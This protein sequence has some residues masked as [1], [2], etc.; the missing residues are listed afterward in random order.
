M[1]EGRSKNDKITN[2]YWCITHKL[3]NENFPTECVPE[4]LRNP[5]DCEK[6]Q[7]SCERNIRAFIKLTI[8]R[9]KCGDWIKRPRDVKTKP[10]SVN[11]QCKGKIWSLWWVNHMMQQ[12]RKM[13]EEFRSERQCNANNNSE[14]IKSNSRSRLEREKWKRNQQTQ[15][16]SLKQGERSWHDDREHLLGDWPLAGRFRPWRQP[17]E[18]TVSNSTEEQQS[19]TLNSITVEEGGQKSDQPGP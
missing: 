1:Y 18:P 14:V 3:I 11:T 8:K 10:V 9:I 16:N 2:I 15:H 13:C 4:Q 6:C 7:N 12:S 19:A 5:G 17:V